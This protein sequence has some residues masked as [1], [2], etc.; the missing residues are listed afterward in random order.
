MMTGHR[1]FAPSAPGRSPLA[2]PT[3]PL[4][5]CLVA[6]LTPREQLA[7][8]R[9]DGRSTTDS[10]RRIAH[11]TT[12]AVAASVAGGQGA[13]G[14]LSA[15]HPDPE[16]CPGQVLRGPSSLAWAAAPD[17][18][19]LQASWGSTS[20]EGRVN[21]DPTLSLLPLQRKREGGAAVATPQPDPAREAVQRALATGQLS[22][23]DPTTGYH[24][25][26]VADCPRDG[27][28]AGVWRLTRASGGAI[29]ELTMHCTRCGHQFKASP[30]ALYLR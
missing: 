29:T 1:A 6:A 27:Q 19:P 20:L 30:D 10:P 2:P 18:W 4:D 14:A 28:P 13:P 5:P 22:V 9:P 25:S 23:V 17:R 11:E 12:A 21:R 15:G 8:L 16:C 24:R 7:T 26:I 3:F